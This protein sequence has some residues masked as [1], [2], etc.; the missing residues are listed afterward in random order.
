MRAGLSKLQLNNL[1]AS[2]NYMYE[3]LALR[4]EVER[5]ANATIKVEVAPMS[6]GR[7][8]WSMYLAKTYLL[9][10]KGADNLLSMHA[11][12]VASER[13]WSA[14]GQIYTT[15]RNRLSLDKAN[16]IVFI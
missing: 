1:P 5:G 7:G 10:A 9:L 16:T 12:S 6:E 8:L 4:R 13:N 11:T 3:G 14:W 2:Y 15:Y